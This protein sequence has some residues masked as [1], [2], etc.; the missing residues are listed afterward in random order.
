MAR[1]IIIQK[2]YEKDDL[3]HFEALTDDNELKNYYVDKKISA[4]IHK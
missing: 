1:M 4:L 2:V 3:L